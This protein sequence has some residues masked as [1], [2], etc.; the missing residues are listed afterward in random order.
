MDK[1]H[2]SFLEH[3]TLQNNIKHNRKLFSFLKD[4]NYFYFCCKSGQYNSLPY[5]NVGPYY[6]L[7]DING[8]IPKI[9]SKQTILYNNFLINLQGLEYACKGGHIRIVKHLLQQLEDFS[10]EL[11]G[12]HF[13]KPFVNAIKGGHFRVSKCLYYFLN[14]KQLF[15]EEFIQLTNNVKQFF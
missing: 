5:M 14:D 12:E 1:Y 3:F 7:L 4:L 6:Y 9:H 15:N 11:K 8:Q 10:I 13:Q 2:V